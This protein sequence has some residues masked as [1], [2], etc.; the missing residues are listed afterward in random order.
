MKDLRVSPSQLPK[1]RPKGRRKHTQAKESH[2]ELPQFLDPI[3]VYGNEFLFG[4]RLATRVLHRDD[5]N[6]KRYM[7]GPD[8]L[9]FVSVCSRSLVSFWHSLLPVVS[10]LR[11]GAIW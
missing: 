4:Y 5:V 10:A 2:A 11:I 7:M 1:Q 9:Y 6:S 3:Q 8:T